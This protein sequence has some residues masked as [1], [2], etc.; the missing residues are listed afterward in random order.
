MA[1]GKKDFDA[2]NCV[3]AILGQTQDKT[4]QVLE[5][6]CNVDDMTAEQIGFAMEQLFEGGALDVYTVSVGMKRTVP[7]P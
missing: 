1:W 2:A 4:D 3:R 6:S 7:G 5:L